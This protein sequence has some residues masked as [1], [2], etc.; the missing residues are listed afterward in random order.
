MDVRKVRLRFR[1]PLTSTGSLHRSQSNIM[2]DKEFDVPPGLK[3]SMRK[4]LLAQIQPS[5]VDVFELELFDWYLREAETVVSGMLAA[6][7]EDVRQQTARGVEDVNDSGIIAAEYCIKRIR[8]SHVIYLTS[9][10]E[11][12]LERACLVLRTV[13]GEENVLFDLS[14]LS[15]DQWSKKRKFLERYGRFELPSDGWS[16]IEVLTSVRNCLVHDNGNPSGLSKKARKAIGQRPGI[17]IEGYEV[18]I[19]EAFVRH[20]HEAVRSFLNSVEERLKEVVQRAQ[21]PKRVS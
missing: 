18:R 17:Y 20:S 12:C 2:S 3:R 15:G 7:C 4:V 13:I 5:T 9:L 11:T 1:S 16:E 14:D 21:H 8:Y 6:E 10:L 19:E